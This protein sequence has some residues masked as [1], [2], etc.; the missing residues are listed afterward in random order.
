LAADEGGA[1]WSATVGPE[2]LD[3]DALAELAVADPEA[4]G[5]LFRRHVTAVH[6]FVQRRC[7][8]IDLAD[9]L[10]AAAFEKAW[11]A[12][13]TFRN[14]R[15]GF[16]PWIFRIAANEMASHYRSESRRG[17]REQLVAHSESRIGDADE[18]APHDRSVVLEALAGLSA[19]NQEVITLRYL[20][21]LSTAETADAL[22][23]TRAHVAV[24]SHRA[25]GALRSAVASLEAAVPGPTRPTTTR[26]ASR[27]DASAP[28]GEHR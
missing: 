7:R 3:D 8:S 6:A 23:I 14:G 11:R 13:P 28:P 20:A 16:R 18:A 1:V 22:G 25:L 10:T 15:G 9:D 12:L 5:V 27:N 19:R 2:S 17:R 21:D 26:A 24:L 4:F